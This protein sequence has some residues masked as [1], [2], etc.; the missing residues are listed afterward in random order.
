MTG[1]I[2]CKISLHKR[3]TL[4]PALLRGNF[5]ARMRIFVLYYNLH[6]HTFAPHQT[7]TCEYRKVN[8]GIHD[9]YHYTTEAIHFC[10]GEVRIDT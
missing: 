6:L 2:Y 7:R 9:F 4:V 8:V 5:L 3:D 10:Q 1:A